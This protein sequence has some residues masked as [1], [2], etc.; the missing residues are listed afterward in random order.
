MTNEIDILVIHSLAVMIDAQRDPA[1]YSVD[2]SGQR[3]YAYARDIVRQVAA[4]ALRKW[5]HLK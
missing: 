3:A 1:K 2:P 4:D 5:D